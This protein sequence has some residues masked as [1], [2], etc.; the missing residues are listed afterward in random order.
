MVSRGSTARRSI[1]LFTQQSNGPP[2]SELWRGMHD[3]TASR[4]MDLFILDGRYLRVEDP[5][6]K[7][8]CR[9]FDLAS[10]PR[11]DGIIATHGTLALPG[12]HAGSEAFTR[13]FGGKPQICLNQENSQIPSVLIDNISGIRES[14]EHLVRFHGRKRIAFLRGPENNIE[15][16]QRFAAYRQALESVGLPFDPSLSFP[17][18]FDAASG[19]ILA[20][21]L[22]RSVIPRFDALIAA[23]DKMAIG[24]QLGAEMCGIRVPEDVALTGFDDDE[25]AVYLNRPLTT[26]RQPF[27]LMCRTA[28]EMLISL[29]DGAPTVDDVLLPARFVIRESCGC[30]STANISRYRAENPQLILPAQ[31]LSESCLP[32]AKNLFAI[33]DAEARGLSIDGTFRTALCDILQKV[34]PNKTDYDDLLTSLLYLREDAILKDRDPAFIQQ[35]E[36]LMHE[37]Q[38]LIAQMLEQRYSGD[39]ISLKESLVLM[40][41]FSRRARGVHTAN[42]L[43]D[44]LNKALP[45]TQ[46][47]YAA[48][49]LSRQTNGCDGLCGLSSLRYLY[50]G[51][52]GDDPGPDALSFPSLSILPDEALPRDDPMACI[53]MALGDAGSLLGFLFF[54]LSHPDATVYE[55]LRS[56]IS[57]ILGR[58]KLEEALVEKDTRER[59]EIEKMNALGTLVAGIAHEINTPIGIGVT[60]ASHLSRILADLRES[61]GR[62]QI[63]RFGLEEF[64]RDGVET[65]RLLVSNLERSSALVSSF[66]KVA[67]D[68]SSEE[69]RF[70]RVRE[71]V[72]DI[73]ATLSPRLKRTL[74]QISVDCPDG[75]EIDSY[76]GAFSQVLSNLVVNSLEHG[77]DE[78]APG[79]ISIRIALSH[80]TLTWIYKDNGKGIP[81][82]TIGHIFEPFFTTRRESGGSG[83]G[84][85]IVYNTVTAVFGGR[86]KV[87]SAQNKGVTFTI[88]IPVRSEEIRY[89]KIT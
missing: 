84:L 15:A 52:V 48:V 28:G 68:S 79:E 51:G 53:V 71:Y 7:V 86:I 3:F 66:K 62:D 43:V 9:V 37:G 50:R 4:G 18:D 27:A 40:N 59:V 1:A 83:L 22:A 16:V 13:S 63:S 73:L 58:A 45:E 39:I 88:T 2:L 10:S 23:N 70:F 26:V 21:A 69:R 41:D 33:L 14:V 29:M 61:F 89:V 64:L 6:E 47:H 87:T 8:L 75:L 76:P 78:G 31:Y 12:L 17:G 38:L 67:V 5:S 46:I 74:I 57:S 60:A 19:R 80:G 56:Q 81:P 77:F 35:S 42:N 54:D 30:P 55:L 20:E 25:E 72:S 24:F 11:I 36:R 65:A 32:D 44:A 49:S 85:H 34:T 82:E